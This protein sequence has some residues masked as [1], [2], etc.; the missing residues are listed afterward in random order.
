MLSY[1]KKG[2]WL[3]LVISSTSK[4]SVIANEDL[5]FGIWRRSEEGKED[6]DVAGSEGDLGFRGPAIQALRVWYQEQR[7]N[8][9]G[10]HSFVPSFSNPPENHPRIAA[11]SSFHSFLGHNIS[12]KFLLSSTS[13][14]FEKA[15]FPRMVWIPSHF[16]MASVEMVSLLM[17]PFPSALHVR[18]KR[19][20]NLSSGKMMPAAENKSPVIGTQ[21]FQWAA[22][23][24]VI[25]V[26][27]GSWA[28]LNSF[29]V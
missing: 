24:P 20:K 29:L 3:P 4:P 6:E 2:W 15:A 5:P 26:C 7:R 25:Y 11:F 12:S 10:F 21:I 16:Q 14:S 19:C 28:F 13:I 8:S 1:G 27:V 9:H 17:R 22:Y 23:I 18:Q